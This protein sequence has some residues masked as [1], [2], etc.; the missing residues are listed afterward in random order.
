MRKILGVFEGFLGIFEETKEKKDRVERGWHKRLAKGWRK[1][2][3]G[4]A[5]GWRRVSGFPCFETPPNR[6]QT[7]KFPL[8]EL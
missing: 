8:E 4:L 5:K 3:E 6:T 1:V 2:G 7:K